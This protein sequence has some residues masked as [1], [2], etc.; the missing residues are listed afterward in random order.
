MFVCHMKPRHCEVIWFDCS[1]IA[2]LCLVHM[3]WWFDGLYV[4]L[5][6]VSITKVCILY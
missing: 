5:M 1:Y 4:S 6:I 3:S 2:I